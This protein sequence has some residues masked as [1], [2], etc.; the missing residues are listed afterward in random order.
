M[1]EKEYI[2]FNVTFHYSR[3]IQIQSQCVDIHI[4]VTDRPNDTTKNVQTAETRHA[5]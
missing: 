1:F 5:W 4:T 3:K 2:N